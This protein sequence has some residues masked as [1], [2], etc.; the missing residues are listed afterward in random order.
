MCNEH[1]DVL[2]TADLFKAHDKYAEC[3]TTEIV[4]LW[5]DDSSLLLSRETRLQDNMT[6]AGVKPNVMKGQPGE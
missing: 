2:H 4:Q 6:P 3:R 5:Y 1:G